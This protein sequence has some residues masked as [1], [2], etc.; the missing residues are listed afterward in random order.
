MCTARHAIQVC[1][2]VKQ[3]TDSLI[4]VAVL[5]SVSENSIERQTKQR[6]VICSPTVQG[7]FSKWQPDEAS[8]SSPS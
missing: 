4:I 5:V 8:C 1:G 7:V 6:D 3:F 2:I